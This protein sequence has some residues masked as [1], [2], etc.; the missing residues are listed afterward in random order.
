MERAYGVRSSNRRL[1]SWKGR[2]NDIAAKLTQARSCS[3]FGDDARHSANGPAG[4]EY[5]G[6]DVRDEGDEILKIRYQI[7]PKSHGYAA[8]KPVDEGPRT[9]TNTSVDRRD[10]TLKKH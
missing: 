4:Y 2:H 1:E 7:S 10:K 5:Y 8:S 3:G 6:K 9:G